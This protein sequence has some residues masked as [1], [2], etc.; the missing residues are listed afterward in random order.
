MSLKTPKQTI[1]KIGLILHRTY[2]F[3]L[4]RVY[5][6]YSLPFCVG[7]F[8]T[9]TEQY[10]N[11][12]ALH[13]NRVKYLFYLYVFMFM[14]NEQGISIYSFDKHK[15]NCLK[16]QNTVHLRNFNVRTVHN[17]KRRTHRQYI[18]IESIKLPLFFWET[19]QAKLCICTVTSNT[20]L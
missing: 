5:V 15:Q 19:F 14:L 8:V 2:L 16:F 20:R 13:K 1:F 12:I 6:L 3:R 4:L 11:N 10:A 7:K 18:Q 17:T 9:C